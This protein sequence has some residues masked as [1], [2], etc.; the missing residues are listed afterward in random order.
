MEL[1]VRGRDPTL[2]L[3]RGMQ[4]DTHPNR[5]WRSGSTSRATIGEDKVRGEG[6]CDKKE[7]QVP[8]PPPLAGHR[9]IIPYQ[10][11][12]ALRMKRFWNKLPITRPWQADESIRA[13]LLGRWEFGKRLLS[14]RKGK[15]LRDGRLDELAKATGRSRQELGFRM[16]FA[17]YYPTEEKVAN[18]LAT[19]TSWRQV[20]Q[21]LSRVT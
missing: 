18:A 2:G 17:D 12:A 13:S 4:Q 15:Q 10:L 19:Y 21:S 7:F 8:I 14:E 3:G 16:R 5:P 1:G 6:N 11:S 20:T 9:V